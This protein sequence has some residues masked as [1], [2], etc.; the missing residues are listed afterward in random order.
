MKLHKCDCEFAI[1]PFG[2]YAPICIRVM[3]QTKDRKDLIQ[4]NEQGCK[5]YKKRGRNENELRK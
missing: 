4:C 2:N 1:F 3:E 5:W